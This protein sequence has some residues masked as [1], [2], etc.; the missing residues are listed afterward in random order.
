[1]LSRIPILNFVK[2]I[3]SDYG[4][5]STRIL[6]NLRRRIVN[7]SERVEECGVQILVE[8]LHVK[9]LSLY[10][11]D[12]ILDVELKSEGC[13]C[14]AVNRG[15]KGFIPNSTMIYLVCKRHWVEGEISS[16]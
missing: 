7:Q 9:S 16:I 8:V 11:R 13:M 12:Y 6:N 15:M 5:I 3:Y 14:N 1:M 10:V 2:A 4:T